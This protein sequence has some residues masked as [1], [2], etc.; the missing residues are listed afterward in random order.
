VLAKT[1]EKTKQ[2]P[3]GCRAEPAE[4]VPLMLGKLSLESFAMETRFTL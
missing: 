3:V 4:K 2:F 1:K